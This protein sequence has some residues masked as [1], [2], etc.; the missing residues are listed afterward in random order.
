VVL[1]EEFL[2]VVRLVHLP[3]SKEYMAIHEPLLVHRE[4]SPG[5][6]NLKVFLGVLL[7]SEGVGGKILDLGSLLGSSLPY[8]QTGQRR[9]LRVEAIFLLHMCEI[10]IV[11]LALPL[12]FLCFLSGRFLGVG[13]CSL[14]AS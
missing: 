5:F 13:A 3:F 12:L 14:A 9:A 1:V 4:I 6:E 10:R 8:L 2:S 11:L 7:S